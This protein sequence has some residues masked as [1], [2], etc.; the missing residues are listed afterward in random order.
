MKD[1]FIPRV[2]AAVLFLSFSFPVVGQEL[3][4]RAPD[5]VSDTS[6][7]REAARDSVLIYNLFNKE[8]EMSFFVLLNAGNSNPNAIFFDSLYIKDFEVFEKRVYFC[9]YTF[10]NDEKK[11]MFGF[12]HLNN[13][14]NGDIYYYVLNDCLKLNKIDVYKTVESNFIE[15]KHLVMTGSTTYLRSDVLVDISL[16]VSTPTSGNIY[17]SNNENEKIDD[18]AVTKNYVIVSTRSIENGIPVIYYWQF[19]RPNA[20]G[21]D[22][23]STFMDRIRVSSPVAQTPVFLEH[24][25]DDKYVAVY[26]INNYPLME[27]TMLEA[28]STVGNGVVIFSDSTKTFH[29]MDIKFNPRSNVYD[30]LARDRFQLTDYVYYPKMQI[31]HITQDVINNMV[32]VGNG[33]RYDYPI[34]N[35][36]SIDPMKNTS[37]YFAASGTREMN[38]TFFRYKHNQWN[39][40]PYK[41]E[42]PFVVGK[43]EGGYI[44]EWSL[45]LNVMSLESRKKTP[46]KSQIRFPIECME[47]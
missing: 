16:P 41:F 32:S 7:I 40:C 28:P 12:F 21:Q 5:E 2:L 1:R 45:L 4:R 6:I 19:K 27:M 15:E 35:L 38:F 9:G 31:Y 44:G 3:I 10:V 13:F 26:K 17:K 22:I 30:I 25:W 11:A 39:V 33:T 46:L 36:W 42:Y 47:R 20:I 23:F 37:K 18:V 34:D 8:E 43:P 14:P 24:T 29:P